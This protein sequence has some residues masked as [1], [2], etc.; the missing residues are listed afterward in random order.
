MRLSLT[1]AYRAVLPDMLSWHT[2][3]APACELVLIKCTSHQTDHK[4]C[5]HR[6][7]YAQ[8]SNYFYS[9]A[10]SAGKRCSAPHESI[11]GA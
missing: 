1:S 6:S 3:Q 9:G 5:W 8:L 2:I 7:K 4:W 10:V 11:I